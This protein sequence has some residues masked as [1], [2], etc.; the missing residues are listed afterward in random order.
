MGVGRIPGIY[1]IRSDYGCTYYHGPLGGDLDSLS[2]FQGKLPGVMGRAASQLA[3][4]SSSSANALVTQDEA[5]L[6]LLFEVYGAVKDAKARPFMYWKMNKKQYK[7]EDYVKYRNAYF[8]SA[9]EYQR[10]LVKSREELDADKEVL[11]KYIEP[12]TKVRNKVPE[13]KKAQDIFYAWVRKA[14]EKKLGDKVDIPKLIK[15]M[16]SESLKTALAKVKV[17]YGKE[18][19]YGGFNPRPMKLEGYRLGT[20]SEHAVGNALDIESATNAHIKKG[21]WKHILAFAGKS[22]DHSTRKAKWKKEGVPEIRTVW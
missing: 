15:S 17:D 13:W 4:G 6:K 3:P 12:N 9:E 16:M 22:L 2:Q 11:R 18:F 7:V 14:Y 10:Y 1:G 21:I 19:Q 5:E 20:I 8:G